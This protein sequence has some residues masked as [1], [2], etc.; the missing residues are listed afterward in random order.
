M[1]LTL[2]SGWAGFDNSH[3]L[4]DCGKQHSNQYQS[5]GNP[6]TVNRKFYLGKPELSKMQGYLVANGSQRPGKP[7]KQ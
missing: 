5:E 2:E 1:I 3:D 4:S 6:G 7:G